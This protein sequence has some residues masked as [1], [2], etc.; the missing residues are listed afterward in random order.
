MSPPPS[1]GVLLLM[2]V[3]TGGDASG[4]VAMWSLAGVKG[5]GG[6]I[7]KT[8]RQSVFLVWRTLVSRSF[9][10]HKNLDIYVF[11]NTKCSPIYDGPP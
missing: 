4:V 7:V 11:I 10:T 6:G 3:E 9:R 5:V 2:R 1:V 8:S